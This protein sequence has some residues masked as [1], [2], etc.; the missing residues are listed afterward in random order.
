MTSLFGT[1]PGAQERHLRRRFNNPL[2]APARR[3]VSPAELAAAELTDRE[4]QAQFLELFR[5]LV[6][7]AASLRPSEESET[8]L[9]LK[10]RLDRA[11]EQCA[12]L[13]GDQAQPKAALRKL[14]EL[15]MV[16]VRRG[17]GVDPTAL[18]EL[19]REAEARTLHYRLLEYPLVADLLRP[20]SP[21]GSEEL[22]PTLLSEPLEATAAALQ[23]FDE[24]QRAEIRTEARALLERA[25]SAGHVIEDAARR[26]DVINGA[27]DT[28]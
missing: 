7:E 12:G 14:V 17:A 18:E 24:E 6:E 25:G 2:F 5:G 19:G 9:D 1:R 27:L 11:Y 15:V 26:M 28:G 3:Q 16:A 8:I 10:A 23:L 21:I 4:E 22:V 20:D 13:G